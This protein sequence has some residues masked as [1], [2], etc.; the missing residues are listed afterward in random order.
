MNFDLSGLNRVTQRGTERELRDRCEHRL[1]SSK[2]L[3]TEAENKHSG[4]GD[5]IPRYQP[6]A[7][8]SCYIRGQDTVVQENKHL[9]S[10]EPERNKPDDVQSRVQSH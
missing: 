3:R 9:D 6:L 2:L 10:S 8:P 5:D 4:F 1:G 7:N